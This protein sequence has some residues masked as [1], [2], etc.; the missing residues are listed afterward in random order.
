MR[1]IKLRVKETFDPKTKI[2]SGKPVELHINMSS[3]KKYGLKTF[4]MG[5]NNIEFKQTGA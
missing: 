2:R 1:S 5:L 4:K 3:N